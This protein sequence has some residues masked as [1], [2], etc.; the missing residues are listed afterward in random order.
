MLT[1][2]EEHRNMQLLLEKG[3]LSSWVKTNKLTTNPEA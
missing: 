2:T 3:K 1:K